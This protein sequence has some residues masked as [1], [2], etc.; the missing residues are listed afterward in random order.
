[1]NALNLYNYNNNPVRLVT[2]SDNVWFVA[3]DVCDVL[4]LGNPAMAVNGLDDDEKGI[5]VVDTLGGPQDMLVVTEGGLYTLVIR[6]N[7][8]EAKTFRKWVTSEVLPTIRKTGSYSLKPL[9]QAEWLLQQA[10]AMVD[11]ERRIT[12]IEQRHDST[13]HLS[14]KAI[15]KA[16]VAFKRAECNL[17]HFSV[18]G[19]CARTGREC[20]L[21]KA[22]KHGRALTKICKGLGIDMGKL[23]D[24]R[25]GYVNSYPETI[26]KN[27]FGD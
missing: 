6:S 11:Q 24:P 12:A 2:E 23:A 16:D 13:E 15:E 26:L 20:D 25:F 9:S 3:K 14:L 10:Q 18:Q 19:Y 22:S 17:G 8:L 21:P 5:K 1:M 4:G 27:Y 7:K